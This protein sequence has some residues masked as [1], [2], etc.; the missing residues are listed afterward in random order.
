M[1]VMIRHCA[2]CVDEI[3]RLTIS[4][5]VHSHGIANHPSITI[6]L[7]EVTPP[8]TVYLLNF[9]NGEAARRVDHLTIDMCRLHQLHLFCCQ[10]L[11]HVDV[12]T[13]NVIVSLFISVYARTRR[14]LDIVTDEYAREQCHA[15]GIDGEPPVRSQPDALEKG[16]ELLCHVFFC[17]A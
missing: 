5:I 16:D 1:I 6:L 3:E 7:G 10:L 4:V 12:I 13:L 15:V 14:V 11:T 17:L 8:A 9:G 2:L